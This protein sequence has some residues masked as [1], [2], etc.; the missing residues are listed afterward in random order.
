M[1]YL[2]VA[3]SFMFYAFFVF[4]YDQI[5]GDKSTWFTIIYYIAT[6]LLSLAGS[7]HVINLFSGR[8]N[9]SHITTTTTK[10]WKYKGRR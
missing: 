4:M 6:F 1:T 7:E 9:G 3:V 10:K 5:G 8:S 2:E